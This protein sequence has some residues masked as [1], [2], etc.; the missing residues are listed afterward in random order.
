MAD[1]SFVCMS[2]EQVLPLQYFN[3]VF[4]SKVLIE[5]PAH[6]EHEVK[7][8]HCDGRRW[9]PGRGIGTGTA[10]LGVT[11]ILNAASG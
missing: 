8:L 4:V 5:R 7:K 3:F 11:C 2:D 9:A 6:T 1:S 10:R